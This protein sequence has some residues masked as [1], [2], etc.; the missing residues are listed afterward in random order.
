MMPRIF[1]GTFEA[2]TYW[3][4]ADLA[5]LPALPDRNSS[6]IVEAMDEMLFAF[7]DPGDTVLTAKCMND[8]HADYLHTIGFQFNRNRFDLSL[9]ND[10]GTGRET[11]IAPTIFQRM[12]EEH[13]TER[14]QSVCPA[15]ARL[16]PFAVL[17][18]TAELAVRYGLSGVFPSQDVI[19]TVNTKGYSLRMRD[20]LGIENVGITVGDVTSLLERG[21]ELLQHGPILV[22]DDYGVSGKGNQLIET[23]R[24]LQRIAKHLSA[25]AA[26]GK[27]VRFILEPYLRKHSD[28]SCQFRIEENGRVKVVSVQELVNNGLAF[29]ASCSP[30]PEFLDRLERD[31]YFQLIELVGSLMYADGYCGDVCVD[32]MILHEGELAPLVEINARK[33]MSLIKHAIDHYLKSLERKGCLTYVSALNDQS[34]DF[35]G[36]LDLLE[37]ERLLF[38]TECLSGILPLTS[39]TMYPRSS[40]EPKEPVRGRLYVA[41]VFEKPE[42]QA[43][44]MTRLVRVM[45]QAGLHVTH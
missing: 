29:G 26:A 32:S 44:L 10:K 38:A 39:G 28:F 22:K 17:P 1:C 8:A 20:R 40:F 13:V 33:S 45:E 37:R 18:G 11:E 36:L 14:L 6:R 42:Q 15:G 35:S 4:E 9:T 3:R 2:E 12:V 34:N 19:R 31:G 24:T 25:Q 5:K 30:V 41:A 27:R 21:S 16:E 23:Q 7:C 43:G